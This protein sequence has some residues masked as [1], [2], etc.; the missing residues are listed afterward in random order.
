[1][2]T[3]LDNKRNVAI[4]VVLG[5]GLLGALGYFLEST[6]RR[7]LRAIREAMRR[8]R[9]RRWQASTRRCTRN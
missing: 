6:S 5:V 4:L 8:R 3:G 2:K 7:R 1:M 9:F